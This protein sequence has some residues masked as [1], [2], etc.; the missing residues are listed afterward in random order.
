MTHLVV[1]DR[2]NYNI[3]K[4]GLLYM[5]RATDERKYCTK[6]N[7]GIQTKTPQIRVQSIALST[8]MQMKI[9]AHGI[10][11]DFCLFPK[12]HVNSVPTASLSVLFHKHTLKYVDNYFYFSNSISICECYLEVF[13]RG[14]FQKKINKTKMRDFFL[15][16]SCSVSSNVFV[17]RIST[18]NTHTFA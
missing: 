9:A 11:F 1:L 4:N 12:D 18:L 5:H 17:L 7:R 14:Y 8:E 10:D 2:C 15:P 13:Q 3:K 16:S 6:I